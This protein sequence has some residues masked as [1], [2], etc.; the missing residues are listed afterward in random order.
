MKQQGV[1][2]QV[3]FLIEKNVV[4]PHSARS[5]FLSNI[6]TFCP[7]AL[8]IDPFETVATVKSQSEDKSSL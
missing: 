1:F 4:R 7:D 6:F 5:H 2:L 8:D 3:S